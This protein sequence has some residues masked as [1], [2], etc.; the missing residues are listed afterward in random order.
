MA[1]STAKEPGKKPNIS[2]FIL[3][4]NEEETLP[5]TTKMAV[6]LLDA[7]ANKYEV[8]IID[9]GSKDKTMD[10]CRQLAGTYR[11]VRVI[12]HEK[13]KGFGGTQKTGYAAAKYEWVTYLPGDNQVRADAVGLML[14]HIDQADVVVGRRRKRMDPWKRKL[15]AGLYNLG[16]R[17]MFGLRVH[18]VDG[19]KLIR[20]SVLDSVAIESESS[21]VDVELLVKAKKKGCRIVEVDTPHYP[22]VAGKSTGNNLKVVLRQ[23]R[24]LFRLWA[25]Q[26]RQ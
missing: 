17:A 16:L 11:H 18:D 6:D 20:K 14:P 7:V 25:R 22:R 26:L 4:Y 13:N 23:F 2:L 8:I 12:S 21:N 1:K 3:A 24:E 19:V 9:D 15:T 5:T 10:V